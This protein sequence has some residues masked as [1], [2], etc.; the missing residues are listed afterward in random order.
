M[1]AGVLAA[2]TTNPILPSMNEVIWGALS[3]LVLFLVL[4]KY[5]YPSVKKGMDNR[6]KKIRDSLDE[7]EHTRQEARSILEDYQRQLADAKNESSRIIEEARQA[8]DKLRQ[9]LKRQAESEVT[10]I[11][12]RAQEDIAAQVDR[13]KADLQAQMAELSI[14]LA[15]RVVE[16][17]LDRETNMDLIESFIRETGARS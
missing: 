5:G 2:E 16:R 9:D 3:F 12:N 1:S 10:E 6:A 11:K 8:A 14:D 4:A 15:E 13:A 7:A 17:S